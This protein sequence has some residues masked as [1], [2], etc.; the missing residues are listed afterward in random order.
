LTTDTDGDGYTADVDCD[1]IIDE[2]V[3]VSADTTPGVT[4]LMAE[5]AATVSV[6]GANVIRA[7]SLSPTSGW[8]GGPT[9][10]WPSA[11]EID[12]IVTTAW[13]YDSALGAVV[14]ELPVGIVRLSPGE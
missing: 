4:V 2:P 3:D 9:K 14:L 5:K 1:H 6:P 8:V 12:D 7:A 11:V 10:N 13:R